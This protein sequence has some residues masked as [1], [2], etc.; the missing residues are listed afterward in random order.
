MQ[1][2]KREHINSLPKIG[3][4]LKGKLQ[5]TLS[6]IV[7]ESKRVGSHILTAIETGKENGRTTYTYARNAKEALLVGSI[8]KYQLIDADNAI[9]VE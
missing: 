8:V 9:I 4:L 5:H 3:G 1:D 2:F 6:G 7:V